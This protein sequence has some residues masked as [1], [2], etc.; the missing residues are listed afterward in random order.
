MRDEGKGNGT[1]NAQS[2][3]LP[4]KKH[5]GVVVQVPQITQITHQSA[6]ILQIPHRRTQIHTNT[7]RNTN[8][9]L[10]GDELGSP[11][12]EVAPVVHGHDLDGAPHDVVRRQ[13]RDELRQAAG[14]LA[15]EL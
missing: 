12:D 14:A 6:Q 10:D 8:T 15:L 7:N 4:Q 13:A 9:H 2:G 11:G 1:N 5:T 3:R